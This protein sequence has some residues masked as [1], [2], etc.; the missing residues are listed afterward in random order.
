MVD[1]DDVC[2]YICCLCLSVCLLLSI[3]HTTLL[4]VAN[5]SIFLFPS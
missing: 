4:I 3:T 5:K 2:Q 1:P